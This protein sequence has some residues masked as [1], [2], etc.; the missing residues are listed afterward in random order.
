MHATGVST[1]FRTRLAAWLCGALLVVYATAI[2]RAAG[3][4]RTV[5]VE[6]LKIEFDSEWAM[7]ASPGYL[8]VRL[9]ITNLGDARVIE[10]YGQGTR[11][12]RAV[13]SMTRAP[14]GW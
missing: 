2:G 4:Y 14:R 5:E 12:F 11:F 8:P 1:R 13:D 6:S 7:R 10:I 9:D 3:E